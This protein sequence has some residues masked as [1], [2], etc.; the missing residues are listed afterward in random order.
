MS[1]EQGPGG[2]EG[3]LRQRIA[4]ALAAPLSPSLRDT[5]LAEVAAWQA[6]VNP[7]FAR[8]CKARRARFDAGPEGW[9]AVPTDLFRMAR[10][11]VH[12]V[13]VPGERVFH[14]SG[15]TSGVRGAHALADLSLYDLAAETAARAQLFPS[16][17]MRLAMLAAH[18]DE[19]PDSSLSYMLGR[20]EA[21]FGVRTDWCWRGGAL[22]VEALIAALEGAVDAG[23]PL[24]LLGT[25]FAFVHALDALD[26]RRWS[27]PAG[28][29]AMPTGGFKGRTREVEPAALHAGL[30]QTLGVHAVKG[31]YGMTELCSQMYEHGGVLWVPPW[32]RATPV[33]PDSLRPVPDGD[34]GLLRLDD[35]ANLESAVSIQ[36]ADLARRTERGLVLLGRAPGASPRGCSLAVEEALG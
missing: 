24:A 33:D 34:A 12:P 35:L 9:P 7:V 26:G 27:L 32:M 23:A 2:R 28:S 31:E 15:T 36:T 21:W 19:V 5:L 30:V 11:S 3:A 14:T 29:F 17:P 18:P 20:F 16:G 1:A 25:S 6:V 13:P 8:L 10:I 4:E 22:D